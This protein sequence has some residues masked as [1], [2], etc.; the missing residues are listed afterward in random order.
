MTGRKECDRW[1]GVGFA[2]LAALLFGASTPLAKSLLPQVAPVLMAGLLYLGSGVGLGIY[3]LI[4]SRTNA[5]GSQEAALTRKD[6]PWLTGAIVA[7][8][9]VGPVLLLWGLAATPASSASLLLN[10]EGVL[11][12]LLAWFVFREN[13]DA[14]IALGMALIAAGG[15][16]VSWSGRPEVG[17]PWGSFAI[18]GACL[19]WAL[20]NNLTRK[21]SAGDPVQIA[22]LKGLVA[23]S[24]NTVLAFTLGAKLPSVSALLAVGVVGFFGYGVSL[25]LFVLALRH[26]G[27]ARSGAYF[28]VAPFVG[29]AISILFLGDKLTLGFGAAVVLMGLGVWLHLTERHKHAHRHEP[30][31]HEHLHSHDVHHQHAHVATDPPGEPHSHG[32]RH[33]EFVH[34]HPHFPDIH[35]R[36]GH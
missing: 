14:R 18:I 27:T 22:M 1:R 12:A 7:G 20:D 32:H 23:G 9:I 25:T 16:C 30:M 24:V 13:F 28:S 17:L 10:L 29:A 3:R 33:E 8:G 36:H 2:L 5:V 31:E 6:L 35:H 15:V 26:I 11:T 34:S 19:A 21:V 4:R